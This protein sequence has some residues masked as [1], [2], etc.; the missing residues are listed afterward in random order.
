MFKLKIKID[1][2]WDAKRDTSP[3]LP[4]LDIQKAFRLLFDIFWLL[5]ILHIWLVGR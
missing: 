5:Q 2:S 4:P 1:V 3:K